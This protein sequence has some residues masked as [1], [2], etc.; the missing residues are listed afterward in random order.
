MADLTLVLDTGTNKVKATASGAATG[1]LIAGDG[2]TL[3][4]TLA[5]RLVG[6]GN[7]T[8]AATGGGGGAPDF[9]L[10]AFGVT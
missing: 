3:T 9:I 4:G 2:V 10:Q 8:I 7:V 1:D 5:G 6:S